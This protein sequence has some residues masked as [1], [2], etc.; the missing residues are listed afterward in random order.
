MPLFLFSIAFVVLLVIRWG[1]LFPQ[2]FTAGH[3]TR[4]NLDMLPFT[5]VC[6]RCRTSQLFRTFISVFISLRNMLMNRTL[7]AMVWQ[8]FRQLRIV[9]LCYGLISLFI[10]WTHTCFLYRSFIILDS[11]LSCVPILILFPLWSFC[12]LATAWGLWTCRLR[13]LLTLS[14]P[15]VIRGCF[16]R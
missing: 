8:S 13:P 16:G 1:Q 11:L 4:H 9:P 12:G 14:L 3:P 5:L 7:L 2:L 15:I 10:F 6:T